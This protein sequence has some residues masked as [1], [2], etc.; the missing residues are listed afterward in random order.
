MAKEIYS[1]KRDLQ[2]CGCVPPRACRC[3]RVPRVPRP[4]VCVRQ[5]QYCWA[6]APS[7][8][9]ATCVRAA[10]ERGGLISF[11]RRT[12]KE[13]NA[14][15]RAHSS[16]PSTRHPRTRPLR[17]SLSRYRSSMHLSVS[18]LLRLLR[19]DLQQVKAVSVCECVVCVCCVC[20]LCV[21]C[22]CVCVC[23]FESVH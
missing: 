23:V 18:L 1:C 8:L 4:A 2:V 10:K 16:T 21:L 17:R 3:M 11:A 5:R 19:I 6:R 13:E 9:P 22:V 7:A 15:T 14:R 20:M 12:G